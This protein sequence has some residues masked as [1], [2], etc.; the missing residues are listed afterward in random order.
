MIL[1]ELSPAPDFTAESEAGPI[2]LSDFSGRR[3]VLYFYPKDNTAG[4]TAEACNFRDN[5]ERISGL[6]AVV[7]GVSPDPPAAH[8]KFRAK[9]GLNF[10]LV[11]DAAKTV[12]ELYGVWAEKSLYGR[13]YMGVERTT[14]LIDEQ[15]IIRRVWRRVKV[16][17]HVAEVIAALE[18]S[19]E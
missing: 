8:R 1:T 10:R 2:S 13:K 18:S 11:S 16:A 15:G 12:C 6:G 17:G 19:A 4:C 7:V 3:V 5:M 14:F 9:Y